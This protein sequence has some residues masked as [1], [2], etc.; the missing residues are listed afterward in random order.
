[1]EAPIFSEAL[2]GS[3]SV[4][5]WI[6]VFFVVVK[7]LRMECIRNSLKIRGDQKVEDGNCQCQERSSLS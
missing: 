2:L 5:L 4:L 7:S 3:G 6:D 1:M